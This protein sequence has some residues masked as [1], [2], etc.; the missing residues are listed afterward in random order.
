MIKKYPMYPFGIETKG[1]KS[2]EDIIEEERREKE[3]RY[4]KIE[5]EL[6]ILTLNR[7]TKNVAKYLEGGDIDAAYVFISNVEDWY[8]HYKIPMP[9]EVQK[10]KAEVFKGLME[11][12]YSEFIECLEKDT[13]SAALAALFS[14]VEFAR[15]HG[16]DTSE[17]EQ[18]AKKDWEKYISTSRYGSFSDVDISF[19]FT[20]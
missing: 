9:P 7:N 11:R 15:K 8:S 17:Y 6:E 2:R 5:K 1:G 18:R 3:R 16:I 13:P 19:Y 10:L 12:E 14:A 20:R 4:N